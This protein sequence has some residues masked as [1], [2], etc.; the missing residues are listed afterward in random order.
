MPVVAQAIA[1][2]VDYQDR[3]YAARYVERLRPFVAPGA[4][5]E[6]ARLVARLLA[7][8]MTYEDAIRVADLKTRAARFERIRREARSPDA[9]IVV[10]DYLKPDLDEIYGILPHRLVAPFA[11]WAE[12]R[13]P[14]A[15][16]T[17]GQHVKTTTI[18]GYLR[19]WLLARCR[20]LRPASYR[21]RIE[22]DRMERWLV[23]VGRCAAWSHELAREVAQAAQLVKGYGDVRR[24]MVAAFDDLLTSVVTIAEREGGDHAIATRLA[25]R[26]RTLALRGPEGEAAAAALAHEVRA[27]LDA[28]DH[29]GAL[30]ALDRP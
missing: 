20:R 10:T 28:H 25:T 26:Y 29:P 3:A 21:A 9:A 6:L 11:R 14:H 1:R 4:D 30:A 18:T 15:R 2:L 7:V 5:V 19:L 16:P 8:W 22:H 27:R 12:R 23:T 24:R 17:L 13:W